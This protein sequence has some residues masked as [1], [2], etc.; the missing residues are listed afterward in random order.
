[1]N[2]LV[3]ALVTIILIIIVSIT[4]AISAS[5]IAKECDKLNAF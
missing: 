3:I 5:T 2:N 1:M 4:W